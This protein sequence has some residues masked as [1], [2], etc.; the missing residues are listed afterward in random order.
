MVSP[1]LAEQNAHGHHLLGLKNSR[2]GNRFIG[3]RTNRRIGL[4]ML[5]TNR[6]IGLRMLK[7]N[8]R[9]L[10]TNRLMLRANR[11]MLKTNRRMLRANRRMLKTNRIRNMA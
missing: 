7:T 6:R 8:R 2:E 11:R 4:R 5:R 9:R 3:L 10:E 1:L